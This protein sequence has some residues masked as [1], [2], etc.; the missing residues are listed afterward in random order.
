[1]K[2]NNVDIT[3]I[4]R[5]EKHDL[6][7]KWLGSTSL[8]VAKN[9]DC[10]VVIIPTQ[11]KYHPWENY[12]L[13]AGEKVSEVITK[14]RLASW[15][16]KR[17]LFVHVNNDLDTQF[18]GE[19][20]ALL[21]SLFD[22][23][24]VSFAFGIDTVKSNNVVKSILTFAQNEKADVIAIQKSDQSL[25]STLFLK[26]TTKEIIEKATLPLILIN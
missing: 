9:A 26:S 4:A 14:E 10:D 13:A 1:V 15:T 3:F 7:E 25:I 19:R 11:M 18:E 8:G 21:S 2:A 22:E 23:S 24:N 17:V 20:R 16:G 6:F 12:I 5:R